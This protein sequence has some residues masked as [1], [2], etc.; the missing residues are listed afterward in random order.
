MR[1]PLTVLALLATF[2]LA[3]S[4]ALAEGATA[5]IADLAWMSGHWSG[6][7]QNGTLEENWIQPTAKSLAALVRMTGGDATS[8][9]EL[10]VIEEENG[11]LMLRVQQWNPGFKPRTPEP[12]VMKLVESVPNKVVFGATAGGGL[13]T[14]GYSRPAPD[15][16]VIS[17]ETAQGAKFDIPLKG[18][19]AA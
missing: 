18:K 19:P 8:M 6:P 13:K 16:F 10:I 1:S 4:P 14:L 5:K 11:T 17:I 7:M 12:Q 15:Q 9:I 3:S 2:G